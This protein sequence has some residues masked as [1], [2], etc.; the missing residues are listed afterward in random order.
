MSIDVKHY[1]DVADR[2]RAGDTTEQKQCACALIS[3]IEKELPRNMDDAAQLGKHSTSFEI[4]RPEECKQTHK[5]N[6][7][8]MT[9]QISSYFTDFNSVEVSLDCGLNP[10]PLVVKAT[11]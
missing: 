8:Y 9:L 10:K 4:K 1:L 2:V 7:K 5:Q 3:A 11:W 6:Y